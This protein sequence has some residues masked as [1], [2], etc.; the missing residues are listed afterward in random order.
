MVNSREFLMRHGSV[1]CQNR[2][3]ERE[4]KKGLNCGCNSS[5]QNF[6][7]K[8]VKQITFSSG[9]CVFQS[10]TSICINFLLQRKGFSLDVMCAFYTLQDVLFYAVF[11]SF[12]L[13]I[14]HDTCR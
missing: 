7:R 9:Q 4:K 14:L 2:T 12:F 3:M 10:K 5:L 6:S 13:E 8:N 1:K 11:I